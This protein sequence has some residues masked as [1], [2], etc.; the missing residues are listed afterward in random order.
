MGVKICYRGDCVN[1]MCTRYGVKHGYICDE[2]FEELVALG[3][4]AN[5]AEFMAS[6]VPE[7]R[8]HTEDARAYFD[9]FFNW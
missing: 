7:N 2:C 4:G 5:I 1:Y 3:V 9:T 6:D 8:D